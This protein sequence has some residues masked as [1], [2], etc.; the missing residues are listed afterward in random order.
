[1][2]TIGSPREVSQHLNKEIGPSE[3]ITVTQEMMGGIGYVKAGVV[4]FMLMQLAG[5][6]YLGP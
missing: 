5:W 3:W 2:L 1:M 4:V 6:A